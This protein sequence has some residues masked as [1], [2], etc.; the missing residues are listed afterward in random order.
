MAHLR[1]IVLFLTMILMPAVVFGDNK[2]DI[3]NQKKELESIRQ[4]VE[5]GRKR[6]DSLKQAEINYQKGVAE[7]DQKIA[8]TKK[9]ISRLTREFNQLQ[10]EIKKSESALDS[11][12]LQ[13]D[14]TRRRYLGNIR[15]FYVA[16]HRPDNMLSQ[17]PNQEL[18]LQR[19]ITYLTALATFESGTVGR[20][21]EY[22]ETTL[23]KKSELSGQTKEISKLKKQKETANVLAV[24]SKTKAQKN[25]EQ[26]RR[27]K[28]E[29]ADRV[30]TLEQAAREM[31][32][33]IARVQREAQE[34]KSD[35]REVEVGPSVFASLKGQLPSPYRGKVA[36]PFGES[37]D[38][39]T[40]LKAF[41]AGIT[42]KGKAGQDVVAVAAG[43]VA[44][45]GNLRGYGNFIIINHD[46]QFY[47]TYAGLGQAVVNTN[48]YVLAGSKLAVSASDGIV[49]FEL[50]RG[51]T[52]LDPVEWI[53]IDSF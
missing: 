49:K 51:S 16:A 39:V 14:L 19:Q 7:G 29:E 35:R 41:S 42:I 9:V 2:N 17:D 4:E 13:L 22:L 30:M 6:L 53:R 27:E 38:P 37:I 23:A 10:Q 5:K 32:Q 24:S 1:I 40:R 26:V 34:R 25:L 20:T 28:T 3:L 11:T 33:I 36:V 44:Y 18:Q 43:T 45:V 12:Q 15:Q 46:D 8:N 48:E 52:P 31:E 47:T 50:R 21:S